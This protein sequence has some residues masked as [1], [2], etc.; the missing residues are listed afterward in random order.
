MNATNTCPGCAQP[1]RPLWPTCRACGTLLI[2]RPAPLAKVGAA[3]DAANAMPSAEEQ[4]FAPA[5]LQPIVQLAPAPPRPAR[6]SAGRAPIGGDPGKWIV[7]FAMVAIVVAAIATAWFSFGPG[8]ASKTKGPVELTPKPPTAA[9]PTDLDAVVRM[10]AESARRSALQTVEASGGAAVAQ[11][12][13]AQPNFAWVGG[14]QA[15]PDS[16][17]VS[18]ARSGAIVTIAV[19]ASNHDVCAFGKWALN[20]T[21]VY[22]TMEHEEVCA[23]VDAP[24][25]GWSPLA[26]GAASDLPDD[27][28]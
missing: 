22:V 2:A 11:L 14:D 25:A 23:A 20:A 19:A 27:N 28:G 4:F 15:S 3:A 12:A 13:A 16:H 7:L 1:V 5:V 24:S 8:G 26:G 17:T 6:S 18:V 9:L 10:E 21:P